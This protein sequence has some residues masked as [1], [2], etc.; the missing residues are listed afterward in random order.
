MRWEAG[1]P[2]GYESMSLRDI[3]SYAKTKGWV[4]NPADKGGATQVGVTLSTFRLY[5]GRN[6]SKQDL[7]EITYPQWSLIMRTYWDRVKGDQIENQSIAN[8]VADW[9]VNS[10][11]NGV[12]AMQRA[13]GL[14]VDGIIGKNS[15]AVLNSPNREVIFNRIKEAREAYYRKIVMQNPSQRV[16]LNGWLNRVNDFNYE[17]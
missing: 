8:I 3:F 2:R 14:D 1:A 10:G 5:F 7:Y 6:A 12:K 4:D 11:V 16:F 13:L 15:L 9:C 17:A